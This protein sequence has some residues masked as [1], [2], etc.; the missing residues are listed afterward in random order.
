MASGSPCGLPHGVMVYP[1][2]VTELYRVY[3]LPKLSFP[4]LA[5]LPILGS[6]E[7]PGRFLPHE[8]CFS[9]CYSGGIYAAP[10]DTT[11]SRYRSLLF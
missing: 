4:S 11:V 8:A 3:L 9:G 2:T 5:T 10:T 6:C 1:L 7:Y